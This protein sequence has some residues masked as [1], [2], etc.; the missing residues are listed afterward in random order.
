MRQ[1]RRYAALWWELLRLSGRELPALTAASLT[2]LAGSVLVVAGVG[3][4][5]RAAVDATVR[6]DATAA[7]AAAACAGVCYALNSSLTTVVGLLTNTTNDRLGRLVLHP[8]VHHGI[9][10]LEGLEHLER[11]DFLDRVTLVRSSTAAR[12]PGYCNWA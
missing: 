11:S 12:W 6:G 8:R 2:A 9:A 5:L 3:L 10:S 7:V 1:A 4:S